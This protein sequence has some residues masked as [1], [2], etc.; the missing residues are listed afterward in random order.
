M[1]SSCLKGVQISTDMLLSWL[2]HLGRAGVCRKEVPVA[3][4]LAMGYFPAL[5]QVTGLR[6]ANCDEEVLSQGMLPAK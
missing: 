1:T 5:P 2:Q 6:S 4:S 3:V